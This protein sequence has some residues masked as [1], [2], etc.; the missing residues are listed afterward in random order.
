MGEE[1]IQKIKA[2]IEKLNEA[3]NMK[4]LPFR[5]IV[6]DPAGN[7]FFENPFATQ[8]DPYGKRLTTIETKKCWKAWAT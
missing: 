7:S 3:L 4:K 8:T 2:F 1:F 6:D 5:F